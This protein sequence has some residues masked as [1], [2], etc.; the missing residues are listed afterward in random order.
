MNIQKAI[1][2]GPVE[3]VEFPIKNGGSFHGKMLVHQRVIQLSHPWW[4]LGL[5]LLLHVILSPR[6]IQWFFQGDSTA[7]TP[8]GL[9]G[10]HPAH[11]R[12]AIF[13]RPC[14]NP[15]QRVPNAWLV[16]KKKRPVPG[17]KACFFFMANS[18][19]DH[20]MIKK[21][22]YM[23]IYIYICINQYCKLMFYPTDRCSADFS[24]WYSAG[25][26]DTW[27]IPRIVTA[28]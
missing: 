4:L 8:G 2:N 10:A 19:K 24:K 27:I 25:Y 12:V 11:P 15:R 1:E 6:N 7:R 9:P 23:Y 5:Q 17:R 14:Q 20:K 21:I 13:G 18:S 16:A 3:I 22:L 28:Q 26:P